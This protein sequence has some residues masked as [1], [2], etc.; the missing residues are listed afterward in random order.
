M[1]YEVRLKDFEGPLDLLLHLVSKAKI[2]LEDIFVSEI[3]SQ[4]LE[5]ME[6]LPEIDLD[7]ASEFLNMAATL[8]YIKS[9]S[10][11]PKREDDEEEEIDPE[12]MLI[13]RLR[14]Y[15]AYKEVTDELKRMEDIG[16]RTFYKLREEAILPPEKINIDDATL[17]A[18]YSAFTEL[19]AQKR[20]ENAYV[21][22]PITIAADVYTVKDRILYIGELL[23]AKHQVHFNELFTGASSR[24]EIAVTFFALLELLH[25]NRV[26]IKQTHHFQDIVIL[27]K[28][29]TKVS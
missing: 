4:Y 6:Q 20:G 22:R 16:G 9:R 3:T 7:K 27:S 25:E 18:L 19:M 24:L 26:M 1:P 11:V 8:I 28:E 23:R 13:E 14:A 17:E 21:E 15:R 29:Q 12:T 2:D 5:Y 10:L